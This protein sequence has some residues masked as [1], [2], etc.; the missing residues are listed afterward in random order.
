VN[1]EKSSGTQRPEDPLCEGI[2]VLCRGTLEGT[3]VFK[4][5]AFEE[6][7]GAEILGLIRGNPVAASVVA[8]VKRNAFGLVREET[9]C[10]RPRRV[11]CRPNRR[12][13][14]RVLL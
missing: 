12:R 3:Y 2:G 5:R 4:G 6:V 10:C 9:S 8:G 13:R 7:E 14:R 1:G 11:G